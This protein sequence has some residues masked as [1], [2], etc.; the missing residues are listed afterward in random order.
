MKKAPLVLMV[1]NAFVWGSL[2]W[3]GW[4][5]I[6]SIESQ[7]VTGYPNT[8]QI[9]YYLASPLIMLSVSLLPMAFLSQTKWLAAANLWGA[10]T[11]ILVFPYLLPYGGGV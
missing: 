8:G 9:G 6:K 7:H 2:S 11:L 3:M 1:L 4:D 5:G 10:L